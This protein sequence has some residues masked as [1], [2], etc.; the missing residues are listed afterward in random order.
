MLAD[1][2]V[3]LLDEATSSIDVFTEH[4]IQQALGELLEGRTAFVVAHRLSTIR[5]ADVVLVLE[6]G[7]IARRG[8]PAEV[9]ADEQPAPA[10]PR[11]LAA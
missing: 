10:W 4:R 2:R 6:N 5:N 9:L 7:R 1:P 3:L 11:Q 8:T